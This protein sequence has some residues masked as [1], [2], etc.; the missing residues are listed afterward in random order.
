MNYS[1]ILINLGF[2]TV[3][4]AN[5]LS[6]IKVSPRKFETKQP[7][8][9][10]P[11]SKPKLVGGV[12]AALDQAQ[13]HAGIVDLDSDAYLFSGAIIAPNYILTTGLICYTYL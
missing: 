13:W 7:N 3:C 12:N 1:I 4:L 11:N 9:N 6:G 10:H 8:S 2:I 5:D